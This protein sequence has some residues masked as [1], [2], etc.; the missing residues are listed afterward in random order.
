[1]RNGRRPA[2]KAKA[3][4]GLRRRRRC[5]SR[6][7]GGSWLNIAVD[8]LDKHVAEARNRGLA[9]GEIEEVNKG[10]RLC[11][12]TD[13]DGNMIRL[14]GGFSTRDPMQSPRIRGC[15]NDPIT[16]SELQR[17][18]GHQT[19]RH[20]ATYAYRCAQDGDFDISRQLG[21]APTKSACPVCN[22]E[23]ARVFR[24]PMLALAPRAL[25]TAI[26]RTEKSRDEPDVVSAPPPRSVR[27][28][29]PTA[30]QNPAWQRLP[31]P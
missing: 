8:D 4:D 26:D 23:A 1:V 28:Q 9:P 5:C 17:W 2:T 12:I 15:A 30:T 13:P 20:M 19:I 7:R 6:R 3:T 29:N 22:N 25:V 31:R 24:A 10:V 18:L 21:M 14:I 11:T 16:L 27:A